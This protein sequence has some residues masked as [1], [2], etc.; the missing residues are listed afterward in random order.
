MMRMRYCP[1]PS[2]EGPMYPLDPSIGSI[3]YQDHYV[4]ISHEPPY[5]EVHNPG[6]VTQFSRE[7]TEKELAG[8][9]RVQERYELYSGKL[10]AFLEEGS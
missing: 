10:S 8:L 2:C 7:L 3:S 1:Q 9:K 5:H 4:C 6:S